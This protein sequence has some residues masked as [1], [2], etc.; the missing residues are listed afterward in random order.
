[1]T[2]TSTWSYRTRTDI[3]NE[4]QRLDRYR[5]FKADPDLE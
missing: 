5:F 4:D 2:N 1:M 3:Q